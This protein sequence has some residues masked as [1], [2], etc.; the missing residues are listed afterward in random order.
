[1]KEIVNIN[2]VEIKVIIISNKTTPLIV[3][4]TIKKAEEV[5]KESPP[6]LYISPSYSKKISVRL[7]IIKLKYLLIY[8]F[9]Y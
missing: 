7:Y 3:P 5:L 1:M 4:P 6:A 8:K 2:N 9:L